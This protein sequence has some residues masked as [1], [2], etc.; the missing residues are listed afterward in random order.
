MTLDMALPLHDLPS[1]TPQESEVFL[2]EDARKIYAWVMTESEKQHIASMLDV[3]E[4][5]GETPASGASPHPP[6]YNTIN[7]FNDS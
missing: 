7:Q 3:P 6:N 4:S 1:D 2:H 5:D